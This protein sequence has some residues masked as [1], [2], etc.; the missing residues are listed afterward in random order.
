SKE[1][2]KSFF[3]RFRYRNKVKRITLGKYPTLSLAAANQKAIECMT[4]A[5]DGSLE[6]Q[7]AQEL[8]V[9]EA[10]DLFI[11]LYAK[12]KNKDWRVAQSRLKKFI[13]EYGN[14]DLM[15][16]HRRDI[17]SHLDKLMAA[18]TPTQANRVHSALS[19]F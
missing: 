11:K 17:I 6:I 16:L 18:G 9:I 3:V 10:H 8:T 15:D 4:S 1:G 19:R 2:T 12:V 5:M 13:K 14:M 7:Q